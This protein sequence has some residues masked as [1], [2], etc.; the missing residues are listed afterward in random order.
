[1]YLSAGVSVFPRIFLE[2]DYF[3]VLMLIGYI[4]HVHHFLFQWVRQLLPADKKQQA[5]M[6]C[7]DLYLSVNG[8]PVPI[9]SYFRKSHVLVL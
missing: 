7:T 6:T 5:Q 9:L 2:V 3:A 4:S 8:V 1:M